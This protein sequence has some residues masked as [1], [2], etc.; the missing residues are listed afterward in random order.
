MNRYRKGLVHRMI[1]LLLAMAMPLCCCM[2]GSSGSCCVP[3]PVVVEVAS[4]CS[5]TDCQTAT[6]E[7]APL[8]PCSGMTTCQCCL[9]APAHAFDWHP[10]I[11]TIG[12][13]I[14][15]AQ[16]MKNQCSEETS[17]SVG[18]QFE[19]DPPPIADVASL[20]RGNVILQV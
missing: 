9:K 18:L 16:V 10:P 7:N 20:L 17:G 12:T 13:P 2:F 8:D 4:C 19:D 5:S 11:D 14:L 1:A 15:M 6:A 3:E